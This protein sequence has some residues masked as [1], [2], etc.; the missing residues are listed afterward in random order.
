V[1]VP[2]EAVI[3]FVCHRPIRGAELA[4]RYEWRSVR[5]E[6]LATSERRL[7]IHVFGK[8]ELPLRQA[9][10]QLVKLSHGKCYHA[11]KK[12]EQLAEA[13]SADPSSQPRPDTDW[14]QQ[15]VIEVEDLM[16]GHEGDRDN[17]GA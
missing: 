1:A 11:H 13:K 12:Q 14:R 10:G 6:S 7:D 5:V 17:R 4:D 9:K 15:T 3:C 2:E 16:P 8:G